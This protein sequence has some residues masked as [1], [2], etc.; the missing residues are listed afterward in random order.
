MNMLC[1][2][3]LTQGLCRAGE[4]APR[5]A[6]AC[7]RAELGGGCCQL[8]T[9]PT[10]LISPPSPQRLA[11]SQKPNSASQRTKS[12]VESPRQGDGVAVA[13]GA[14][15]GG[16]GVRTLQH[17]I[18]VADGVLADDQPC[19]GHEL[20]HIGPCIQVLVCSLTKWYQ[21]E[22]LLGLWN[23]ARDGR[24]GLRSEC[25]SNIQIEKLVPPHSTC[26]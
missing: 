3:C 5:R 13:A 4:C 17:A 1:G 15:G 21:N 2:G 8:Q 9:H 25:R 23:V 22:K 10:S 6:T 14:H 20:L 26:E 11:G 18:H 7:A 19:L 24:Q 12:S 16:S